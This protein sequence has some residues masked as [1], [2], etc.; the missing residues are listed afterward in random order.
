MTFAKLLL[1]C[2]VLTV[3]QFAAALPWLWAIDPNSFRRLARRAGTWGNIIGAIAGITA[4]GA[5]VFSEV[6][7]NSLL[8]L[9]GRAY[10]ALL[11]LQITVDLF[12]A[13]FA[14]LLFV[15]PKGAAV[16]LSAFREGVRQPLFWLIALI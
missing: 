14:I 5:L 8:E 7:G 2:F 6:R 4:L 3:V 9:L 12:I 10:G 1:P 13:T 11:H 15:W 16:A